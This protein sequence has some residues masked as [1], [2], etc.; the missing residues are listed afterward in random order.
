M[1]TG[2]VIVQPSSPAVNDPFSIRFCW[3]CTAEDA[4]TSARIGAMPPARR[5]TWL[6][7]FFEDISSVLQQRMIQ[8]GSRL[9][10]RIAS[11]RCPPKS[12]PVLSWGE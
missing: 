3:A 2:P 7:Y 4:V 1:N 8:A 10:N 9:A 5:V 12:T 11:C 6:K